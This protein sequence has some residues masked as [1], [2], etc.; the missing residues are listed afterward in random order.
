MATTVMKSKFIAVR[1][2]CSR[3]LFACAVAV[4]LA[5]PLIAAESPRE[6]LSL[7]GNWKFH[8]GN[9][10]PWTLNL[11]KAGASTGPASE[12]FS[13]A[14]WRTVKLPHDWAV[15]LPFDKTSN[16]RHGFKPV[17]PGFLNNSVGWYRRTFELPVS[18]A[19]KRI[20]LTFDGVYRDTTVWVNGWLVRRHEG[21]YSPFREDITDVVKFGGKNLL[22]VQVD[23]SK[24][25]GWFYEGAGIYRHVWLDK[26]A[27]VAIAPEG[28]FVHSEFADNLPTGSPEIKVEIQ[29][30]NSQP[31]PVKAVV[32][33]EILSPEGKFV[34]KFAGAQDLGGD[35]KQVVTLQGRVAAPEL[36]S[37]ES[38]KLYKLVTTVTVDGKVVDVKETAF[39][40]RTIAFH[41]DKG[42]L[43]NGKPYP[44]QGTCNHQDHA[45]VGVAFPDALQSFRVA[46]LKEYGCNAYR[47]SHHPPTPELLDACD[48]LGMLVMD[49]CRLLGSDSENLR[50]WEEQIRRD[51]N[52]PSVFI[53]S[54]A[55]EEFT[56]HS[57][58]QGG[59]AARSM[60]ALAKR[61]DPTRPVTYAAP[62]GD[63]TAGINGV[64]EVRGW[65]YHL[66]SATDDYHRKNPRQG[67]IGTEQA[68]RYTTRGNY[69]DDGRI[70]YLSSYDYERNS[71]GWVNSAE[72][73][74]TF[75]HER[76]WLSGGF[77]WTGFDYRGEQTP[78]RRW[79]SV[80]SHFGILDTCGF[81]KDNAFYYKA[82][83]TKEPVLHLV[84]SHWN[85]PGK[86]GQEIRV[87]ALTNCQQVELFLNGQ[88]IGKKSV[89]PCEKISFTAKYASGVLS[90]K[91]FDANGKLLAE[92]KVETTGEPVAVKLTRE[93][94]GLSKTVNAD[95]EDLA[96]F[97][98]SAV[99]AQGRPV[100]TAQNPIQFSLEG[101]GKIIG[102]GNGDPSCHEPDVVLPPCVRTL[103]VSGW[104]WK[105]EAFPTKQ[106]ETSPVVSAG[107]DESSWNA[108]ETKTDPEMSD[109]PVPANRQAVYR[110]HVNVTAEDLD[111]PAIRIQFSACHK[112]GWY[113]I[114]GRLVGESHDP[115][116]W[117][118]FDVKSLLH[119]GDN[120]IAV[121]VTIDRRSGGLETDVNLE[122][123]PKSKSVNWSRSLFNGLA[124]IMVQSSQK[125]GEIRLNASAAGL[126]PASAT[127]KTQPA[128]Q[129]PSAP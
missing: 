7:D 83:W 61:L 72:A 16:V 66:D 109:L 67:N 60:Q 65:N 75:M 119:P 118:A 52:H 111:S 58:P 87:D 22:T 107:V 123:S 23:A 80:N 42:F 77:V 13:G 88:S 41:K 37:P 79:P 40:L 85:W 125:P 46:R 36:W 43:L 10:Y 4:F 59:N 105:L 64:I 21:G 28:I 2:G 89:K 53:W 90:A 47:T 48:R 57:T 128:Q 56:V 114:N 25:E 99:D 113:F 74:W 49:E 126:Q 93:S 100:P 11:C 62:Q 34:A 71:P 106:G 73:W 14:S 63:T 31:T 127:L 98:V 17:G 1:L 68:S 115:K 9:D 19:G 69:L 54:V 55:N 51:R 35:S 104:R 86:E 94:S 108:L 39:G 121:G 24:F 101:E 116:K 112:N 18:D 120:V 95:G 122:I 26:T 5:S 96:I 84:P 92:D 102:V 117:A 91:G 44:V 15:E 45:G 124:Q 27:P 29:L 3:S 78:Y 6:R 8:L 38:P 76:P 12:V 81:P 30:L 103:A 110:G 32:A 33:C 129:R 20:W 82:V 70:C 97:A 50:K